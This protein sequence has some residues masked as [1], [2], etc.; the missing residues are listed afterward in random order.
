MLSVILGLSAPGKRTN[1]RLLFSQCTPTLPRD[2]ATTTYTLD[3]EA[4]PF[5]AGTERSC[6]TTDIAFGNR[7]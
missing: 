2:D 3:I 1:V 6:T 5:A 4:P 7:C